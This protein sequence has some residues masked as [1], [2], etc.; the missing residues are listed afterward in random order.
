M[1]EL[2]GDLLEILIKGPSPFGFRLHGGDGDPLVVVKVVSCF[3]IRLFC[4]S[5]FSKLNIVNLLTKCLLGNG[6]I[7][8]ID[9]VTVAYV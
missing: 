1:A 5:I 2:A 3:I 4:Y 7:V 9:V 8:T 6:L